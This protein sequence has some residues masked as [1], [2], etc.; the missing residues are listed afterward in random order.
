MEPRYLVLP[1]GD[2]LKYFTVYINKYHRYHVK[3]S[4]M[5]VWDKNIDFNDTYG[6]LFLAIDENDDVVIYDNCKKEIVNTENNDDVEM[7]HYFYDN[8]ELVGI[9]LNSVVKEILFDNFI[10]NSYIQ[11]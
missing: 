11:Y 8:L 10:R 9:P 1:C 6:G 2:G 5:L 7:I 3:I 4:D